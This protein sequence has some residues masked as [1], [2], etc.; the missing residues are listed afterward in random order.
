MDG[1]RR[2]R[3]D[4]QPTAAPV[5]PLAD[6]DQSHDGQDSG[7][8]RTTRDDVVLGAA[9]FHPP[10]RSLRILVAAPPALLRLAAGASSSPG[11]DGADRR[12][13]QLAP[14]AGWRRNLD[15]R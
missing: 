14:A 3:L 8:L 2:H 15:D 7:Q 13:F 5:R 11:G 12:E 6:T 9:G 10:A 1:G 4:A